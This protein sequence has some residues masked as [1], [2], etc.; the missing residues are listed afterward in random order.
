MMNS[1]D[2]AYTAGIIDGEGYI[3]ILRIQRNQ[4]K[5]IVYELRINV[6]MCN[7]LIPSWLHANFGGSYYEFQPPSLNHKKLYEWRLATW[8]AGEFLKLILP[9]LKM[10]QGEAEIGI[11]FQSY[12]KEKYVR[13]KPKPIAIIEAEAILHKQLKELHERQYSG[14]KLKS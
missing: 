13:C 4:S 6:T 8:R 5:R 1:D 14:W 11:K 12:R 3:G 10:K 2:L 7:P 9:Y